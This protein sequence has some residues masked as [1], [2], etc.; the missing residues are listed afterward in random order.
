[1]TEKRP[2][3]LVLLG[4][5]HAHVHIIKSLGLPHNQQWRQEH[6]VEVT[7]IAKDLWT[8]YSGMLPGYVAGHYAEERDICLDLVPLCQ[9]AGAQLIH[10][11]ANRIDMTKEKDEKLAS[12]S[13]LLRELAS[14]S[15]A[16]TTGGGRGGWVYCQDGRPP[17]HFDALSIDIGITPSV[18]P[19]LQHNTTASSGD[20]NGNNHNATD[21]GGIIP[22]K[23]ISNFCRYYR[24][25]QQRILEKCHSGH[26]NHHVIAVIGGG[27]GGIEL[28]LALQ[29]FFRTRQQERQQQEDD[30]QHHHGPSDDDN[31]P[32]VQVMVLTR[33]KVLLEQHNTKVQ[34]IFRRILQERSVDVF[35]QAE[36][37][38]VES[39]SMDR[40]E[41]HNKKK[42]VFS[43]S[44]SPHTD[45][46]KTN[47]PSSLLQTKAE[48]PE[49]RDDIIV[50]DVLW[51]T[52]ASAAS[53]LSEATPLE[54]TSAGHFV[55]VASTY[56]SVSHK[57][58]F[59]CGDCCHMVVHPRP[60]AGVFA[61]RAGPPLL[62]NLK[63]YLSNQPLE[64]HIPQQDFLGI[65]STGDKYAVA[66]KGWWFA[67]EGSWMW[68][69]KDYID[70]TWMDQYRNLAS[71]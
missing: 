6:G 38:G 56:E 5:G 60:K 19:P 65:I 21:I 31:D 52:Q 26:N 41:Q 15:F 40:D 64:E 11:T 67:L 63:H 25:L 3:H 28:A 29:Y 17:I 13:L 59:A 62:E 50:D 58:V 36:V 16:P 47:D 48:Q 46:N 9:F 18:P 30:N 69:L 44:S 57:G 33:S 10:A 4:G 39:V 20:D 55:K 7:V 1:M 23:P 2:L 42:L 37:V 14:F 53:W 49:T 71:D 70:R 66:S 61:V 68:T 43:S 8:P 45:N 22:V 24:Q 27:A 32:I 12:S 51:C 54:T 35:Y 34:Q